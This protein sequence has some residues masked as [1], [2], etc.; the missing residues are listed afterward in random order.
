M[1]ERGG[2]GVVEQRTN[3]LFLSGGKDFGLVCCGGP[4]SSCTS[5]PLRPCLCCSH[6]GPAGSTPP[7]YLGRRA[8]SRASLPEPPG[9]EAALQHQGP[10]DSRHHQ[11][12]TAT[13]LGQPAT[14]S[15]TTTPTIDYLTLDAVSPRARGPI[16]PPW[17][18]LRARATPARSKGDGPLPP[19]TLGTSS[20]SRGLTRS[21][22]AVVLR[23]RWLGTLPDSEGPGRAAAPWNP[24][25]R[26]NSTDAV[27]PPLG[28]AELPPRAL[29][30]PHK[31]LGATPLALRC[32]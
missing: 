17:T 11:T 6:S 30:C 21:T 32:I 18:T 12:R 5:V 10:A 27:G 9:P 31:A 4:S 22:Q 23:A 7:S 14:R 15:V 13:R 2:S 24:L 1:A 3:V 19:Y 8:M 25:G 28:H 29:P 20:S 26:F 16:S